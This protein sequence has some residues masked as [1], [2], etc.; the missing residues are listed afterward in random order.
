MIKKIFKTIYFYA[1]GRMLLITWSLDPFIAFA[2]ETS[3]QKPGGDNT[4]QP[5]MTDIH[6]IKPLVDIGGHIPWG[7]VLV[8]AAVITIFI[9]AFLYWR[10][11]GKS[12]DVKD[13]IVELPPEVNAHRALNQ[14]AAVNQIDGK[15][16]YYHLS[17]ILRQY[18]FERFRLNA[19]EMTT[20]ELLPRLETLN[21]AP[22]LYDGLLRLCQ[23]ADPIK[24]AGRRPQIRQM[25]LDLIFVRKFVDG[26][27]LKP[28][29]VD[30]PG[31]RDEP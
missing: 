18:I 5:P 21:L 22:E 20:E 27:T 26:T 31:L 28:G 17:A 9:V 7:V 24:F 10:H 25:E 19:P 14:M 4:Q 6:D 13:V 8:V 12:I 15:T 29:D 30:D 11:L 3:L 16:F 2:N 1:Y 23:G